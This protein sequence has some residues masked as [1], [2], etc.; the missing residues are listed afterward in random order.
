[1]ICD[2]IWGGQAARQDRLEIKEAWADM[3]RLK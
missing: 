1:M 2:E 3:P